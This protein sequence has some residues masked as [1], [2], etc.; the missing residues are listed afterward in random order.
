MVIHFASCAEAATL[1]DAMQAAIAMIR[2]MAFSPFA[3]LSPQ[4]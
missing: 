1:S 3:L 4:P 2:F